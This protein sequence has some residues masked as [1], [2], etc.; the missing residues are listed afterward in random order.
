M[1]GY[2]LA[3]SMAQPSVLQTELWMENCLVHCLE[4]QRDSMKA[5]EWAES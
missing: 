5:T 3:D 2:C 1:T 4:K